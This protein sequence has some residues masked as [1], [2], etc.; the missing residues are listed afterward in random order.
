MKVCVTPWT[1]IFRPLGDEVTRALGLPRHK[2]QQKRHFVL[3][4]RYVQH[5]RC[6]WVC[7]VCCCPFSV[8]FQVPNNNN[9]SSFIIIVSGRHDIYFDIV[10]IR[11]S[12]VTLARPGTYRGT[13]LLELGERIDSKLPCPWLTESF[14]FLCMYVRLCM[15]VVGQE[16]I[17]M[18]RTRRTRS[19]TELWAFGH[20][21]FYNQ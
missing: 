2:T 20:S 19:F 9:N 15:R 17:R 8:S 10:I 5:T 18:A 1:L 11:W 14:S 13:S 3:E 12:I 16:T 6:D 7:R 21:Q 4:E